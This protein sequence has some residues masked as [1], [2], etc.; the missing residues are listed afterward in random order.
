MMPLFKAAKRPKELSNIIKH[1]AV[2][3]PEAVLA[4]TIA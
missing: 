4:Q 1:T 3:K 2:K